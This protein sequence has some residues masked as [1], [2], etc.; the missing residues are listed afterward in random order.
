MA[1][2][3][4]QSGRQPGGQVARGRR[5]FGEPCRRFHRTDSRA[6]NRSGDVTFDEHAGSHHDYRLAAHPAGNRRRNSERFAVMDGQPEI[7]LDLSSERARKARLAARFG[8]SGLQV[9]QFGMGAFLLL[10]ALILLFESSRFAYLALSLAL[11]CYSLATWYSRDLKPLAPT[12][13]SLDER[14]SGEILG[15]LRPGV[16]L[17]PRIVWQAIYTHWQVGFVTN[18]LLLPKSLVEQNVSP[19][20]SGMFAT[21]QEAMRLAVAT[22]SRVIEPCHVA[23]AILRLSPNVQTT[24][25]QMKL[26]P[27]DLDNV[28]A[29]LMRGL[30]SIQR[31]QPFFG[32]VGRDWANGF[33]P[34]L[35]QFGYNIS[36]AVEHSGG[37]YDWLAAS[38]SVE[39]IKS[40][41]ASGAPAVT[42]IGPVGVGKTE[43]ASALAQALLTM[44]DNARIAHLQIIR[45]Q[46]AVIL[47]NARGPGELEQIVLILLYEAAHAGNV[48]LFFDDAQLFFGSG[49]GSFDATQILL[50]V[51]QSHSVQMMFAM[52]P[53]DYQR[54]KVNN[55]AFAGLLTPIVL[56]DR[57]E[58]DTMRIAEDEALNLEGKHRV[59]IAYEAIREA[60]RLSGR[61]EQD[62][63]YPG[64]AIR[65][66]EQATT[67]ADQNV[68][69][70][71]SVQ[72]TIEQTRG[73]KVSSAAP[74]EADKLLHLEDQ[75]HQR[76][77]N[78][79]RAVSVVAA[80][81]RRAR[82]GVS[83]PKRPIG[84]FLFLGPTGVGKTE[85][86]KSI[87]ATYFGA[88]DNMIRLDMSEYQQPEDVQRLLSNGAT[89]TK[90]LIMAA[91]EQPFSVVLLDE[92]EKAHPNILNL[93]LQL[94]DEGQLTDTTG[95]PTSFKD[96]IIICTSNAGADT[97]RNRV[98]RGEPLES[99]EQ[100]FTDQ[101]INT[102]QFK[103]ELLN[104]FDEIV[105]F[106]PLNQ[107]ELGQVVSLM[108]ADINKTLANQNISVELTPAGSEKIVAAGYDPRLGARP[109]RR[110][111]QRTVQDTIA[112]R[113]L[114]GQTN[115]GDHVVLDANDLN[116]PAATL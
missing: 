19:L 82:A 54:L 25:K 29:W 113:I 97:I 70:A 115:P 53:N 61:Y 13:D 112:A 79:S 102:G 63:A 109:M 23:G 107:S 22:N 21:W 104:R 59:M 84:S 100:E 17:N 87:A 45:L 110:M 3:R 27:D 40:A 34:R 1:A 72:Q 20:E 108:M 38:P 32:G 71:L 90:S 81:L 47:A 94:L 35:N 7:S 56:N 114:A 49:P 77:I 33:T 78:Q 88:E 73:V 14:L 4:Q 80:A 30:E 92:I 83:N 8:R 89:D 76:M 98:A 6:L 93:L 57:S 69:T 91:R 24:L 36:Q 55:E 101:L 105:L 74:V 75:I 46:P 99:F 65:L 9:L 86:A 62:M 41:L 2:N 37:H 68:V 111:L 43:H 60:Y 52:T 12:G 48:I 31:E 116:T 39:A 28:I 50:P 96:C 42:L 64:K 18:H 58:A 67:H 16:P 44:D 10:A 11:I 26:G 106:R 103:P 51:I 66:L 15:L 5:Q 85:L 95:R